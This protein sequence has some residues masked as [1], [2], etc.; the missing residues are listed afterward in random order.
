[1]EK[2]KKLAEECLKRAEAGNPVEQYRM[3]L[4]CY[5]GKG[6]PKDLKKAVYWFKQSAEQGYTYAQCNLGMCYRKGEGTLVNYMEAFKLFKLAADQGDVSA[7]YNLGICY[8][9]GQGVAQDYAEAAKLFQKSAEM[10]NVGES[11][12]LDGFHDS[13]DKEPASF[14]E[15]KKWFRQAKTRIDNLQ[16]QLQNEIMKKDGC[17]FENDETMKRLASVLQ[18]KEALQKKVQDLHERNEKNKQ[19]YDERMAA[20]E[21]QMEQYNSTVTKEKDGLN[22]KIQNLNEQCQTYKAFIAD[23]NGQKDELNA[24]KN[25]LNKSLKTKDDIIREKENVIHQKQSEVLAWKNSS[26]QHEKTI[27]TQSQRISVLSGQKPCIRKVDLLRWLDILAVISLIGVMFFWGM[28]GVDWSNLINFYS[29][30][31]FFGLLFAS[32][33][34]ASVVLQQ[35]FLKKQRYMIHALLCVSFGVSVIIWWYFLYFEVEDIFGFWAYAGEE[36]TVYFTILPCI[37]ILLFN[38]ILSMKEE[39][40]VTN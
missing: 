4:F 26:L 38:I 13:M 23:L 7:I 33:I 40:Y 34:I 12:P 32:I 25:E 19:E 28:M 11:H 17:S 31:G 16:S 15:A 22:A 39:V 20:F 9:N 5:Y 3:G 36:V 24:Q 35:R 29:E 37:L 8:Y 6:I 14:E 1:M 27:E 30:E 21:K 2:F 18:E 10:G